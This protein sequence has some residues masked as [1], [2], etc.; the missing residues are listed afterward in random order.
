MN[1]QVQIPTAL[2]LK[3]CEYFENAEDERGT[4]LHRELSIKLDKLIEREYFTRYK[5]TISPEEREQYRQKYLDARGVPK[6][7]RSKTEV[8]YDRL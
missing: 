5:C 1:R 2:F 6:S 8:P 7:F 3:L 4:Y